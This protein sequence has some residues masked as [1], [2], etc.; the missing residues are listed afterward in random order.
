MH[1][2][3]CS[4]LTPAVKRKFCLLPTS[5]LLWLLTTAP[6]LTFTAANAQIQSP[7]T[8]PVTP[9]SV[10]QNTPSRSTTP[11]GLLAAGDRISLNGRIL[12]AA[13]RQWE[14]QPATNRIQTAISDVGLMQLGVDLLNTQDV[15]RQPIRWFT[16]PDTPPL[17]SSIWHSGAYRYLDLSQLAAKVGWQL[18][19]EGDVLR[20]TTPAAK[21]TGLRQGKQTWGDRLVVDLDRPTPWQLTQQPPVTKPKV[22]LAELPDDPKQQLPS[23]AVSALSPPYQQWK[24]AIDAAINPELAQQLNANLAIQLPKQ[25]QISPTPLV[26]L[27][28]TANLTTIDLNLPVGI[29]PRVSTLSQPNRVI[30]DL[31][32]DPIVE[33]NILWARGV[34]WQQ[35]YINLGRDRF[36][37]TWLEVNPRTTGLALRPIWSAVNSLIGTAPIVTTAQRYTAAA[38]INAGFFNRNNKLPL[39]AIRREGRWLSSPILNRGAIAWN[40]AG[41]FKIGRL[42]RQETAIAS[43]GQSL[44]IVNLNSGYIQ[45]GIS[46]YTSD[47]GTTYTPLTNN[48]AIAIVQNNQVT[49]NLS[50]GLAG[51]TAFP[52]PLNGYLLAFRTGSTANLLPIGTLLR[53]TD[54]TVPS[55]FAQYPHAIGAGPLLVQNRQIVLN[56]KAEGFSDAFSR[57]TAV[58]SAIGVTATGN[59]LIATVH[60]R[61]GGTG[62]TL[63]ETAKLLQQMGSI[64][65]LNLDGGSSTSL[66]L[67]GQLVNRSPVTAARVHNGFGIFLETESRKQ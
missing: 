67:G 35:K 39:G 65:A 66:Y 47:W 11:N 21:I 43:T 44:P 6:W 27:G 3:S 13:W 33:R 55:E 32:P 40:D 16:T 59:L 8:P 58:R 57:Q 60:N 49:A 41:Q 26:K 28:T 23:Q 51:K 53:L 20:I 1:P 54:G 62:S 48:E 52:I 31:R 45:A 18:Q 24:I 36:P 34:R 15:T 61:V 19:S 56:A 4:I 17:V 63:W 12:S 37:V 5:A 30:I 38:A 10:P 22:P 2:N 29:F 14:A 64:D 25:S 50:G 7:V 9:S 42:Q 46:R